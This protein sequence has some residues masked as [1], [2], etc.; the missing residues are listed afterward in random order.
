MRRRDWHPS[1]DEQDGEQ[2]GDE[3]QRAPGDNSMRHGLSRASN[4]RRA[5]AGEDVIFIRLHF[6]PRALDCSLIVFVVF[7]R[8]KN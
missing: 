3:E 8:T 7:V 2:N 1:V 4:S 6:G 5:M